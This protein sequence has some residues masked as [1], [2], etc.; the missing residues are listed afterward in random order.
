MN[1]FI[2]FKQLHSIYCLNSLVYTSD[3]QLYYNFEGFFNLQ[4]CYFSRHC[5]YSQKGSIVYSY[6]IESTMSIIMCFFYNCTSY[7]EGGAI[8]FSNENQNSNFIL[9][10]TCSNQCFC[11]QSHYHFGIIWVKNDNL[12][13]NYYQHL[14]LIKS[15]FYQSTWHSPIY[16]RNG[17]Q[18]I[19]FSN[20]SLN[21]GPNIIS[22]FCTYNPNNFFLNFCNFKDNEA[23]Q[24][25]VIRLYGGYNQRIFEYSNLINNSSPSS[26]YGVI[27]VEGS[28]FFNILNCIFKENKLNLFG[29]LSGTMILKNSIIIHN[30]NTYS[31][32]INFENNNSILISFTYE[33]QHYYICDINY[34]KTVKY[35]KKYEMFNLLIFFLNI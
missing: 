29:V 10:K 1:F 28:G 16:I 6:N 20:I 11:Y 24:Y 7:F 35:I 30:F 33:I 34:F 8:Y 21:R 3:K 23:L 4:N 15:P 31:G 17:N 19:Q 25:G 32:N 18:T 13:K 27:Y 22:G 12:N 5:T 26:S 9:E 14:S 2:I